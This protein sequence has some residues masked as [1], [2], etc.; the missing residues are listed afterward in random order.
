MS[1]AESKRRKHPPPWLFVFGGTAYGVTGAFAAQIMPYAAERAH[2]DVGAIGWFGTLMLVPSWFQ[3]ML[4][5]IVD[6]GLQ[7]KHWQVLTAALSAACLLIAFAIP[8]EEHLTAYLA[9]SVSSAVMAALISA[10]NGALI[11]VTV[12][13][14]HRGAASAW[15]NVGNLSGGGISGALGIYMLGHGVPS[16]WVGVVVAAITVVPS[17]AMLLVIEPPGDHFKTFR[18]V[19]GKT[20]GEVSEAMSTRSAITGMLLCLSPVGTCALINYFSGMTDDFHASADVVAAVSG[21]GSVVLTAVGALAGGYLADRYNRRILYL[22]T[23]VSTACFA[24]LMAAAPRTEATYALGV[25]VYDLI[26]GVSYA[27]FTAFV[28]ETIGDGGK[29]AATRYTL[30]NSAANFAI[31]Y[32]GLI[33]TRFHDEY[34]AGGVLVSDAALNVIGAIVLGTIFWKARSFGKQRHGAPP[35]I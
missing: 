32:V 1:E 24:L 13:D 15:Y 29:S 4:A 8:L 2:I 10:C 11:A 23:G 30:Y 33:D 5:P 26:T 17:L 27:V 22:S 6:V 35:P 28:L 21:G 31:A 25:G 34:G 20:V 14:E 9:F 19:I 3:F 7:R 16:I 18:H 12:P